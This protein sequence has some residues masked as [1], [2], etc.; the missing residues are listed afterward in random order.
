MNLDKCKRYLGLAVS[1]LPLLFI[2]PIAKPDP[3]PRLTPIDSTAVSVIVMA[4]T[5]DTRMWRYGREFVENCGSRSKSSNSAP[6]TFFF[7]PAISHFSKVPCDQVFRSVGYKVILDV[8]YE[9]SSP[10]EGAEK[11]AN[12]YV[13]FETSKDY[14]GPD[15]QESAELAKELSPV[16]SAKVAS[17]H[18]KNE[19]S[20]RMRVFLANA[21]VLVLFVFMLGS[22]AQVGGWIVVG[23][24]AIG[25]IL[26]F[27]SKVAKKLHEKI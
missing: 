5:D 11:I 27:G 18:L 12:K 25:G 1:L 3:G 14:G 15:A 19:S 26:G 6:S 13:R 8:L 22:R 10:T 23:F 21:A 20:L 16:L 9:P 24:A 7:G 2:L 4:S 17:W